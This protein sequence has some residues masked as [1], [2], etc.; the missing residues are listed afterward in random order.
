MEYAFFILGLVL[1]GLLGTLVYYQLEVLA[2][3]DALIASTLEHHGRM[4]ARIPG[5]QAGVRAFPTSGRAL[6]RERLA[7]R[8]VVS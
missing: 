2:R 7:A 4:D 3:L 1:A 5:P 6:L 8:Q